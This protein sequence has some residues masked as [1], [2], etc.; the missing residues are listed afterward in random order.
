MASLTE[1]PLYE[2]LNSDFIE[3]G[4]KFLKRGNNVKLYCK[5]IT[6][7]LS[8][9][10]MTKLKKFGSMSKKID[11]RNDDLSLFIE[12]FQKQMNQFDELGP[13]TRIRKELISKLSNYVVFNDSDIKINTRNEKEM[14]KLEKEIS[15]LLQDCFKSIE[16]KCIY[17]LSMINLIILTVLFVSLLYE[18][19][20]GLPCDTSDCQLIKRDVTRIS[21]KINTFENFIQPQ[22]VYSGFDLQKISN[23]IN[24]IQNDI[25]ITFERIEIVKKRSKGNQWFNTAFTALSWIAFGWTSINLQQIS[26]TS[27]TCKSMTRSATKKVNNIADI[28]K[29]SNVNSKGAQ[30]VQKVVCN[31]AGLIT[32]DVIF[33]GSG[34]A[35]AWLAKKEMDNIDQLGKYTENLDALYNAT[36]LILQQIE[37]ARNYSNQHGPPKSKDDIIRE[38]N[39]EIQRLKQQI[40]KMKHEPVNRIHS[41]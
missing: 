5:Q 7:L 30:I 41:P 17:Q 34:F 33:G 19:E 15:K 16:G 29:Y 4:K 38:K 31:K 1:Q 35:F 20:Y 24:D 21:E 40:E 10:A 26:N 27:S 22:T 3:T 9:E 12:Y 14:K 8:G 6:Y 39:Q 36:Q 32:M 13:S 23:E 18:I 37:N 25:N 11:F 2:W 28:G